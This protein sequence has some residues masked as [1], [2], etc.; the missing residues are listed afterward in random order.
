MVDIVCVLFHPLVLI[1]H[2]EKPNIMT[3]DV[4]SLHL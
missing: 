3:L 2:K 4:L 1:M